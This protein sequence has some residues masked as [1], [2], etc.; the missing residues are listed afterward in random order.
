MADIPTPLQE[1][2]GTIALAV[3]GAIRRWLVFSCQPSLRN[4]SAQVNYLAHGHDYFQ[5]SLHQMFDQRTDI[6]AEPAGSNSRQL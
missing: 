6:K 2:G 3:G 1:G 4:A 5:G